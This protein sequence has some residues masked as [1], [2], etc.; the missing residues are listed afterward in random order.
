MA[1]PAAYARR[2]LVNLVIDGDQQRRRRNAELDSGDG[3][4]DRADLGASG[5]AMAL[6]SASAFRAALG[7][8]PARQRAVI[9]LRYWED[10]PETEVAELLGCSLGTV[11]SSAS[12]GLGRL[13]EVM[14]SPEGPAGRFGSSDTNSQTQ[15]RTPSSC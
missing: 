14:G 12:R 5:P 4:E 6:E 15:E 8:L 7:A 2:I 10:L 11:K 9:V 13:R 3:V 1:H